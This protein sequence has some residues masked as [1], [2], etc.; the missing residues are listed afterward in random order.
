MVDKGKYNLLGVLINA[1]DYDAAVNRVLTAAHH[2]QPLTLS[3]L[4][5]HGVMTGVLDAEQRYRLNHLDIV[6]PDGQ[7]VRWALNLL[8]HL[9]LSERVYGPTLMLRIC[10]RASLEGL[11][12]YLYGSRPQVLQQL[13][14]NLRQRFPRLIIA[15]AQPS[16]FR[17]LTAEEQQA[18]AAHIRTSGAA[19]TFVG[20]GCPRQEVWAYEHRDLLSMPI[21]AVGAAFDFHA[22]LLPQAPPTLQRLGLEWAFRLWQEPRRLWR[23]YLLLNPL[24]VSLLF[25]QL[26]KL[27]RF[28][29]MGYAPKPLRYG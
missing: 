21:I 2:C 10:E 8:Y 27:Q 19:I 28:D 9:G 26:A 17:R 29:P 16:Q 13:C 5:V 18:I 7:P 25:A 22:G 15:G 1:I 14:N 11:P 4:A 20:L 3:A 24:Y 23:R 6:V 12:I